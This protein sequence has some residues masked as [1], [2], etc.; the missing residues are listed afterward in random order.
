VFDTVQMPLNVMDAHYRSFEKLVLPR[1]VDQRI[2]VLGMKP[3]GAGKILKSG[4]VSAEECLR[5]ALS[6]ETSTVITGCEEVGVLEQA[7]RVAMSFVPMSAEER[8]AVLG[9][10]APFAGAG[11]Y[12]EF[13]TTDRHDGTAKNPQWLG[14]PA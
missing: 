1:L 2:G 11:E 8:L 9:R 5:Y 12:E 14:L 7:L 4:V 6:L 13:K 3:L 10:T